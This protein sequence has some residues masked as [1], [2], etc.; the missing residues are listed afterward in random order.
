MDL[1]LRFSVTGCLFHILERSSGVVRVELG[2]L[3][4]SSTV[5]SPWPFEG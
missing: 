5:K 4:P 3:T 2:G 1:V